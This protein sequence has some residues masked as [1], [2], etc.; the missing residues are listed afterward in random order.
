MYTRC[1]LVINSAIWGAHF[2]PILSFVKWP[3]TCDW[4]YRSIIVSSNVRLQFWIHK[5]TL[6]SS[7]PPSLSA[8]NHT[9]LK[10]GGSVCLRGIHWS[11]NVSD[12]IVQRKHMHPQRLCSRNSLAELLERWLALEAPFQFSRLQHGRIRVVLVLEKLRVLCMHGMN[13]WITTSFSLQLNT[14]WCLTLSP[15]LFH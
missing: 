8:G 4:S 10:V 14:E 6:Y 2:L 11:R 7:A 12:E 9:D 13:C 15:S 3:T 1:F 5:T